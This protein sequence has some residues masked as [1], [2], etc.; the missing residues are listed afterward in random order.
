[1][2]NCPFSKKPCDKIK[3]VH[4]HQNINGKVSEYYC[5][6][7]CSD[8]IMPN[9]SIPMMSGFMA[10]PLNLVPAPANSLLVNHHKLEAL[11]REMD[12][13]AGVRCL[14]CG[15]SLF[16]I[17]SIGRF[18][19]PVCY[20]TFRDQV[21]SLLPQVQA[22]SKKHL[23]K[24]PKYGNIELMKKEMQKAVAEERYED[25]AVLRDRLKTLEQGIQG[26]DLK[27]PS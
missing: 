6:H 11:E 25:A 10:L 7:D 1:M 18:G 27:A 22:G 19:C 2:E 23:G 12:P 15:A 5:C 24:K 21:E 8:Q 16:E 13:S 3:N 4:V 17:K 9:I 26:N 20:E 14:E